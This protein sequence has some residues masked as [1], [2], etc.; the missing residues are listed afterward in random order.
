MFILRAWFSF[1][2]PPNIHEMWFRYT[3][4]RTTIFYFSTSKHLFK[5]ASWKDSFVKNCSKKKNEKIIFCQIKYFLRCVASIISI[6]FDAL[7]FLFTSFFLFYGCK[8]CHNIPLTPCRRKWMRN[9]KKKRFNQ[10]SFYEF[11]SVT[12]RRMFSFI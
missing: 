12:I 1:F 7:K 6:S 3:N 5:C 11:L 9:C 8:I 4:H 10:T 2:F